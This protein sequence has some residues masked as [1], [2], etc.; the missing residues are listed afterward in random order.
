MD[1]QN[2]RYT[3]LYYPEPIKPLIDLSIV[4]ITEGKGTE[5][6]PLA[7]S[8]LDSAEVNT[9]K[10]MF[11]SFD[12]YIL[13]IE[14]KG[15]Q[16]RQST[17]TYLVTLKNEQ[18]E[19]YF[20][21][22]VAQSKN[23]IINYLDSLIEDIATETPD[24]GAETETPDNGAETE[25]PDNGAETETPDN[26]AETETPDNGAE[27]ET[28]GNGA[29]TETPDNESE[30]ETPDNGAETKPRITEL[31]LK[32]RITE[33]KLKLQI[34]ELKL[35]LRIT[36]LRL[37]LQITELKLKLQITELRLKL[38]IMELKTETPDNNADKTHQGSKPQT[39]VNMK[40]PVMFG[41]IMTAVFGM[42]GIYKKRRNLE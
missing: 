26:G 38:Q 4:S 30:T 24:N 10:S 39:G 18:E 14:L 35:K 3:K 29:E 31:R 34:T 20:T 40:L 7:L 1:C 17:L 15:Q 23:E 37:K 27:T 32:P 42:T 11:E 9:L 13:T 21:L 5:D 36:E 8:V 12:R 6:E 19:Y 33:L 28:P 16:T 25:T 2:T 41:G 22:T